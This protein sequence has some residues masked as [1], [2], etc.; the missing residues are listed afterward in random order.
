MQLPLNLIDPP[1][2]SLDNGVVGRNTAA[3]AALATL[4]SSDAKGRYTT[5]HLWGAPGAGKSFWLKAWANQLGKEAE[6]I[7]LD[8]TD[9][10]RGAEMIYRGIEDKME[11]PGAGPSIWLIDNLET[12]GEKTAEALFRLYNAA[13]EVGDRIVSSASCAPHHLQL[14]DDLRTR[15]GQ[16]LIFEL[17][18]LNDDEKKEAL[19]ER[20]LRLGLPITD[21]LLGYLL[22]RLPRDLGLLI[23]VL[24]GLNELSLSRQRPA[25]IPLLK[26]LLDPLHAATRTL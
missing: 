18:E 2:P 25:T 10:R 11:H 21:E 23:G 24:D 6:L 22:T 20:A 12:A 17:H 14:R 26:E 3:L 16:S 19:R 7:G 1:V 5:M 8:R 15:I 13:R 9:D 4:F